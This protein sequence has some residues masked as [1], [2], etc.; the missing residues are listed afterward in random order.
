MRI[1]HCAGVFWM[2]LRSDIPFERGYFNDFNQVTFGIDT[3]TYHAV[4]LIFLAVFIVEFIAMAMAFTD[5]FFTIN[6]AHL[7]A[8]FELAFVAAQ[9]H[10]ASHIGEILLV[11]HDVYDVASWRPSQRRLH[12]HSPRHCV[13]IQ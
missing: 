1:Q 3:D 8:F 4:F 11:F 2:E 5:N 9:A 10:G 12:R 13:Q 6:L 7:A